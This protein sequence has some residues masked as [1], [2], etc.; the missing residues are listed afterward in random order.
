MNKLIALAFISATG[1]A[2]TQLLPHL[3]GV[4]IFI[5]VFFGLTAIA[6]LI[7]VGTDRIVDAIR[8]SKEEKK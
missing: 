3:T 5:S 7:T 1:A 6:G 4:S 8:A 2:L